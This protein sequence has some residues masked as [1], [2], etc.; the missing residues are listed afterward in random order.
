MAKKENNNKIYFGLFIIFI[1]V[2]SSVG[3]MYGGDSN[4]KKING[5]KFTKT[6]AGWETYI[7][8]IESYWAFTYLPNEIDFEIDELNLND[9]ELNIYAD[10]YDMEYID[11]FKFV[12]L[13]KGIVIN[14][15]DEL[16]C[17]TNTWVLESK[18]SNSEIIKENN[19]V[20]L[21][22]NINKFIDGLTYKIFGVI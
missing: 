15:V 19:C 5:H 20:Y 18:T 16:D 21:K 11:E 10:R 9:N 4:T 22:G 1:M 8:Q 6:G 17:N 12:L 14:E 3:F 7:D 2:S 13:Y